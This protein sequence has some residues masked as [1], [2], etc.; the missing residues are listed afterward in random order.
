MDCFYYPIFQYAH[1]MLIVPVFVHMNA[2]LY[3]FG[4]I[5]CVAMLHA[6]NQWNHE[7]T[8]ACCNNENKKNKN[9]KKSELVVIQKKQQSQRRLN[10]FHPRNIINKKS[11]LVSKKWNHRKTRKYVKQ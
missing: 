10:Y 2:F 3:V 8:L 11:V 9:K 6:I 4:C 5:K 1:S 7:Y